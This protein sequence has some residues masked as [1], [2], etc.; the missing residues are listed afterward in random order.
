MVQKDNFDLTWL[1]NRDA[2]QSSGNP[3][4]ASANEF[5]VEFDVLTRYGDIKIPESKRANGWR[6]NSR[7]GF[8]TP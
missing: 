8:S 3:D 2:P 4:R 6:C 1:Q 7:A 5:R